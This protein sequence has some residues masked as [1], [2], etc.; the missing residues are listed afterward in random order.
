MITLRRYK[1]KERKGRDGKESCK[2]D[3]FL[4]NPLNSQRRDKEREK[5]K[6]KKGARMITYRRIL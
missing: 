3:Y 6:G 1:E 4:M 5:G 2:D